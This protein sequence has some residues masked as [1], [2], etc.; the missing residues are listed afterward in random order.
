MT[1]KSS[2]Y[3]KLNKIAL[4]WS[5]FSELRTSQQINLLKDLD[6]LAKNFHISDNL[7]FVSA[8]VGR[9]RQKAAQ[10]PLWIKHDNSFENYT[11]EALMVI[12]S[13]YHKFLDFYYQI[14]S[15]SQNFYL[16][17]P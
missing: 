8:F 2:E 3:C 13:L 5:A 1:E 6:Q 15:S 12:S 16:G 10:F 9:N 11:R 7:L 17:I 14:E 4:V